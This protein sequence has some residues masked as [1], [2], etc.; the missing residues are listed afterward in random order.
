MSRSP[1]T[2]VLLA[3]VV[4]FATATSSQARKATPKPPVFLTGGDV[5]FLARE[6]QLGALYKDN[7]QPQDALQI[8]KAHGCNTMRLRLWVHPD[9][10]GM[11]IS[12]LPYTLALGKR[13]KK[14]GLRLLL[15]LHYSD[16]WADPA[17]QAKPAAWKDLTF[18]QLT[19]QV[20]TY[21]RDVIT[22]FRKNGAMPDIVAVGNE[23]PN[24]ML[25]PDGK[26]EEPGGWVK[27]GALIKA[28]LRGIREGSSPLPPPLTMIHI[29][30]GADA[31]L[32]QWF[33]DNL[34][35]RKQ[36]IDFDLIGLSFYPDGKGP[37]IAQLTQS[38][39]RTAA[40]Y[41]KPIVIAETGYPAGGEAHP[42]DW[43]F[44]VTPEGQRLFVSALVAA[45]KATPGGL[46][47]GVLY[48]EPEWVSVPGLGQYYGQ[49]PLFDNKFN[50]RPALG[51]LGGVR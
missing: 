10:Q 19:R 48:W 46:G 51:A 11:N 31:G 30:N 5:S 6:E 20:E 26:V 12:D 50:A 32:V 36:G 33:F 17:H 35:A 44:P 47:R 8:F 9:G 14:A 37:M 24:G 43:E 29:N 21:S 3:L 42:A 25:W 39:A 18:D 7:G 4:L 15:D 23:T 16:T 45:V 28:G 34:G 40:K 2:L 49:K 41:H 13:I 38:L 1:R 27:Y 22:T